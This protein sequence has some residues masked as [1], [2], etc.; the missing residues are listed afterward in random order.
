MTYLTNIT[1]D[2]NIL[3]NISFLK[4]RLKFKLLII[5]YFIKQTNKF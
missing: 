2:N 3:N 4:I 1:K 5:F